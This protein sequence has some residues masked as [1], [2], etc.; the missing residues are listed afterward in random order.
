M[1]IIY[2]NLEN[3][4]HKNIYG[5][6]ISKKPI[7]YCHCFAHKGA[8]TKN[9]MTKHKCRKKECPYF[10]KNEEHEYW[11]DKAR[12]KLDRKQNK[13]LLNDMLA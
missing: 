9:L 1:D 13:L 10:M 3:M 2:A 7:G 6:F 4:Q 5:Q 8:L 11:I 12:K